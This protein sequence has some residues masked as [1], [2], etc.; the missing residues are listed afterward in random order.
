MERAKCYEC[1]YRGNVPGDTH[2]CCRYPGNDTNLFAMF[3]QTNLVQMIKLGIK[4]DRYGFEN[5]WFMR[6]VNFDP[7][8][9]LNCNGFTPKDGEE[10][11]G[12]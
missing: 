4:A 10:I 6:P 8:W 12:E 7:I 3:E 2:S 1:K 9:L 5:G 11:N